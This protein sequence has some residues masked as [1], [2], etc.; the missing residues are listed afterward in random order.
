MRIKKKNENEKNLVKN[1]E[2]LNK[3]IE[4]LRKEL[5]ETK[6]ELKLVLNSQELGICP[7][8]LGSGH[9]WNLEV[10][11][12]CGISKETTKIS[13]SNKAIEMP[14]VASSFSSSSS[15]SSPINCDN[16][17]ILQTNL[18]DLT[19]N[20]QKQKQEM[21]HNLIESKRQIEENNISQQNLTEQIQLLKTQLLR[22]ENENKNENKTLT[23][24]KVSSGAM[25]TET[26]SSQ[27]RQRGKN[28]QVSTLLP[29]STAITTP[30][31]VDLSS[32][33]H[34]TKI[35]P[36]LVSNFV[37]SPSSSSST[38]LSKNSSHVSI[39]HSINLHIS[40]NRFFL[41]S[42]FVVL[43]FTSV[44]FGTL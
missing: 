32:I 30:L 36:E 37:S 43:V 12:E 31:D 20:L 15:S 34:E 19:T 28:N 3:K 6:E 1:N 33:A 27:L 5:N 22:Y 41:F 42:L 25:N 26:L 13:V 35:E 44:A 14:N 7:A 38:S 8:T 40:I 24:E 23:P 39:P 2:E 17:V 29:T 21:E 4:L 18:A 16:C 11:T 9:A 10:C